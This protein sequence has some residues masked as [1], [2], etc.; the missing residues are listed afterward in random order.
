METYG[1][2]VLLSA[3]L[4]RESWMEVFNDRINDRRHCQTPWGFSVLLVHQNHMRTF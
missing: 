3:S 1:A 4:E 2:V